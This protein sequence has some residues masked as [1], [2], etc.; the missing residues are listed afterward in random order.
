MLVRPAKS[1]FGDPRA[2]PVN[3]QDARVMDDEP[4]PPAAISYALDEALDLLA[5]L[6]DASRT[7]LEADLLAAVIIL[8][9]QI[10]LL[11]RKLGFDDTEGEPGDT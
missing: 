8:D 4:Q 9:H 2:Q 11:T 6:E 1:G 5:D 10:A 7:M 3:D